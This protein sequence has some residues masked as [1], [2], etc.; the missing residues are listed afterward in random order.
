MMFK[1]ND[2]LIGYGNTQVR[3]LSNVSKKGEAKVEII[4]EGL[5]VDA[6]RGDHILGFQVAGGSIYFEKE[7]VN[8]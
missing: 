7:S 1:K 5:L 8:G 4:N 2:K 3:L 6:K